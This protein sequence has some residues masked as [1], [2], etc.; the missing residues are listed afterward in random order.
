[1]ESHLSS[2]RL[3][4]RQRDRSGG[5]DKGRWVTQVDWASRTPHRNN[6]ERDDQPHLHARPMPS[7]RA[8]GIGQAIHAQNVEQCKMSAWGLLCTHTCPQVHENSCLSVAKLARITLSTPIQIRTSPSPPCSH[9]SWRTGILGWAWT[10]SRSRRR[11][12]ASG[13]HSKT[14]RRCGHRFS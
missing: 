12:S 13:S 11:R 4:T 5:K 3:P 9:Q 6:S 8:C 7:N 2:L 1:M 10:F 14:S